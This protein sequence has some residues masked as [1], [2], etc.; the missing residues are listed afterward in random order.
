[1]RS[2]IF[3]RIFKKGSRTYFYSSIFF[4]EKV[5]ED[6]FILYSFVRTVD[7]FVDSI[8]QQK[9]R[10]SEFKK[11]F[12][13]AIKK[14]NSQNIIIFSFVELMHRKKIPLQY[15][16]EFFASMEKDL[17]S[18]QYRTLSDTL[19]Y[20]YGSA[21]V[22]GLMMAKILELPKKSYK[23]A[24]LLGRAMQYA[25]FIRDIDEDLKLG[26][27]YIPKQLL[28]Q[29]DLTSLDL[30][31]TSDVHALEACIREQIHLALSWMYEARNAFIYIPFRYRVPIQ[32]ATDMY[33]WTLKNI[34]KEPTVVYSKKVKPSIARI[35]YTIVKTAFSLK[36]KG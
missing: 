32:T 29:H 6:V 13:R 34:K 21:E 36:A 25:N 35:I 7:D 1:M 30:Y 5:K 4:P 14:N 23:G 16:H 31:K 3:R 19:G 17:Q 20:M 2:D 27:C 9:K 18:K 33:Q 26:R 24:Q 12:H 11:E 10:Y 22:I 8:P 28:Q 15:V